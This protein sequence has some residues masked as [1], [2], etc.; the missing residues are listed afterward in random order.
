MDV[1]CENREDS[2]KEKIKKLW[3]ALILSEGACCSKDAGKN[4]E[5]ILFTLVYHGKNHC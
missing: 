3:F 4:E 5:K 2:S 1:A